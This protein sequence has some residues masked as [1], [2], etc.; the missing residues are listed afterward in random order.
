MPGFVPLAAH[1][2]DIQFLF[3]LYHGGPLGVTHYLN[4]KEEDLS[5]QL[6]TAWTNFAWTGNP[7]GLGNRPWPRYENN[8]PTKP[9]YSSE[10]IPLATLTDAQ[11]SAAHKCDFWQQ[12]LLYD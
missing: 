3:P 9:T 7:N 2:I 6:V 5:D 10:N 11:Y 12:Y 8:R 1:T 4:N